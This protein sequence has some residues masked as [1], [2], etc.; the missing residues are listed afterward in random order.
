MV[1]CHHLRRYLLLQFSALS[2][3]LQKKLMNLSFLIFV[4]IK[5]ASQAI[6][7]KSGDGIGAAL[8]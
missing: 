2:Q 7:P 4:E 5:I 6:F 8:Q 3:I 1:K